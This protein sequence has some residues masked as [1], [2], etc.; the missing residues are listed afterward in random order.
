MSSLVL[1]NHLLLLIGPNILKNTGVKSTSIAKVNPLEDEF[2]SAAEYY[3][4]KERTWCPWMD[5]GGRQKSKAEQ[6]MAFAWFMADDAVNGRCTKKAGRLGPA[7]GKTRSLGQQKAIMCND[8][9]TGTGVYNL[10]LTR[11]WVD[12]YRMKWMSDPVAFGLTDYRPI[13]DHHRET[14][15]DAPDHKINIKIVTMDVSPE[16][17]SSD[18][19]L[20]ELR[21][22]SKNISKSK[23]SSA[24]QQ[25]F[26]RAVK[27]AKFYADELRGR[28][29]EFPE[30]PHQLQ[31]EVDGMIKNLLNTDL[32]KKL[33][34]DPNV[35]EVMHINSKLC[36]PI[37]MRFYSD[38]LDLDNQRNYLDQFAIYCNG[39]KITPPFLHNKE[40]TAKVNTK[41]FTPRSINNSFF[42]PICV[43]CYFGAMGEKSKEFLFQVCCVLNYT[44]I[45]DDTPSEK[46]M[47]IHPVV[48]HAFPKISKGKY[49]VGDLSWLAGIA[50]MMQHVVS[51]FYIPTQA[52]TPW[53]IDDN[54]PS[55]RTEP[56]TRDY[57]IDTLDKNGTSLTR[58]VGS[59]HF[60]V[61]ELSAEEIGKM[62]GM[63]FLYL[64]YGIYSIHAFLCLYVFTR[65]SMVIEK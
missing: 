27:V 14:V 30:V 50:A 10:P 54:G 48:K 6:F 18:E 46:R 15:L 63:I 41:Y 65:N 9:D 20:R 51:L 22:M 44:M 24:F 38:P 16:E 5:N 61:P 4:I 7:E 56:F 23:R 33:L 31:F 39:G 43:A 26:S 58:G 29:L 36:G 40:T 21:I 53:E 42:G 62:T 12:F 3:D 47:Q 37:A 13:I 19:I 59:L 1:I 64:H 8:I 49:L 60:T 57:I 25:P 34:S 28:Q 11:Q 2:M 35:A 55:L 17:A 52:V 32:H 45:H